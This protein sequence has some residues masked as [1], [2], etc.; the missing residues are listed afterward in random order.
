[1]R[2]LLFWALQLLIS[3]MLVINNPMKETLKHWRRGWLQ[4]S[5]MHTLGMEQYFKTRPH[6]DLLR[7]LE[8]AEIPRLIAHPDVAVKLRKNMGWI[9]RWLGYKVIPLP[10]QDKN[11]ISAMDYGILDDWKKRRDVIAP[12]FDGIGAKIHS[13]IQL[14]TDSF[15]PLNPLKDSPSNAL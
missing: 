8:A 4:R 15:N 6:T 9:G 13:G 11:M 3:I 14:E 12:N 10:Y 7:V 1:M 5:L 2:L